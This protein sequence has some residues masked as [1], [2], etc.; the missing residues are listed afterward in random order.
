MNTILYHPVNHVFL[1]ANGLSAAMT[2]IFD[3]HLSGSE[4]INFDLNLGHGISHS[5]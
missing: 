4:A 5:V 1:M 3:K 2:H